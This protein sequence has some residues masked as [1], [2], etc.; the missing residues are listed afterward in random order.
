MVYLWTLSSCMTSVLLTLT[1]SPGGRD[2]IPIHILAAV[3]IL[4]ELHV[5]TTIIAIF[6]FTIHYVAPLILSY[7]LVQNFCMA[8]CCFC[9]TMHGN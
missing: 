3:Q 6:H 4:L 9:D 8:K 7:V 1:P 5:Y 2:V